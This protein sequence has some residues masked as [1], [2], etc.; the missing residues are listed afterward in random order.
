MRLPIFAFLAFSVACIGQE[1][2]KQ[3][4]ILIEDYTWYEARQLLSDTTIVVIP[5]G[6]AAKEHGPHLLLKNDFLIAEY[7]K[8]RIAAVES[9]VIY[10]TINYNYYPAFLEYAGSTSLQLE[11]AANLITD[12]CRVISKHGPRKFYILNSG[13]STLYPLKMASEELAHSGIILMYTDILNIVKDAEEKIRQQSEGTHADE[14]ETSMMLYMTPESVNMA[15]AAKDIPAQKKPGP[16]TPYPTGVGNYSP[17]GI[18]GDATLATKEKG[19]ILVE[20]MVAGIRAEIAQLKKTNV[21]AIPKPDLTK[22]TGSF[23][24]ANDET[25][26][27][28]IKDDVLTLTQAGRP[29][30]TLQ[31]LK[32]DTFAVGTIGRIVFFPDSKGEFRSAVLN[33]S[34]REYLLSKKPE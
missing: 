12:I 22:F 11:T 34:G 21:P 5:L 29:D 16:L 30:R 24:S 13:V 7:L 18:Y 3:Q 15:K 9:T 28:K 6:A 26:I 1:T 2:S 10:P 4:S 25:A 23:V 33:L 27:L 20:A 19:A 32:P 31:F 17:T 14:M 8:N